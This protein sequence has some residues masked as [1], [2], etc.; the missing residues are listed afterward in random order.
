[1][2]IDELI[3]YLKDLRKHSTVSNELISFQLPNWMARVT[4]LVFKREYEDDGFVVKIHDR[5]F[6]SKEVRNSRGSVVAPKAE[7]PN[8]S[9]YNSSGAPLTA[10][11]ID[12]YIKS[13]PDAELRWSDGSP[14]HSVS[15]SRTRI[16]T[17]TDPFGPPTHILGKAYVTLSA[18]KDK[19][20]TLADLEARVSK[21][22]ER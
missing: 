10:K 20:S 8:C 12:P 18:S 6:P 13:F 15:Y 5:H 14:V 19:P 21:L 1:M 16:D 11:D 3:E 7:M 17:S 9:M 4:D 22:E 2:T